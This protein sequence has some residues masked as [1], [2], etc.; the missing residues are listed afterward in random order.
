MKAK[1]KLLTVGVMM[2]FLIGLTTCDQEPTE[3][4]KHITPELPPIQSMQMELS[5]FVTTPFE[6]SLNKTTLSLSKENFTN[7]ALRV[8]FINTAV[9]VASLAPTAVFA[10]ALSQPVELKSDGKFH[11]LYH[12][13]VAK[14]TFSVDLA[15][16]IDIPKTE[17]VW[18][19]YVSSTRHSPKLEH[20][21]WYEGRSRIG[22]QE[23]WWLFHDIELPTSPIDILKIDWEI[24]DEHNRQLIFANVKKGS[25]EYGDSL[26]Y[27][28][29]YTDR[30][31]IFHDA[32]ENK[33]NT[34]Y[35]N[36]ESGAGY[37]EWFDYK[38]GTRSYWDEKK[39]DITGPP[40]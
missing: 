39:N 28:I 13:A 25:S 6:L 10:A 36:A 15:G 3:P 20:F 8:L 30:V 2:I 14:D 24:P 9:A 1:T 16:W 4:E 27:I 37:I 33:I 32:S 19:V 23:G 40:A 31:I 22:N 7:A 29:E 34:I 5:Y 12:V 26:K 21:L 18:E 11:W 17:A 38:N 35:W